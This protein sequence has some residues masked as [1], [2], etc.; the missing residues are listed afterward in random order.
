MGI[1]DEI[2]VATIAIDQTKIL[3]IKETFTL[4]IFDHV[5]QHTSY[6]GGQKKSTK[7]WAA[8]SSYLTFCF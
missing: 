2:E 1:S 6:D 4:T 8:R 3:A 7:N 5:W